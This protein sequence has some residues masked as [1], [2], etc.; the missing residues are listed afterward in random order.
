[1]TDYYTFVEDLAEKNESS[2]FNEKEAY[3]HYTQLSFKRMK[4][5]A[6]VGKLLPEMEEKIKSINEPQKWIVLTESWCG[7]AAHSYMFWQKMAD[8]NPNITL[9]WKLREEHPDLM[10]QYLTNGG[11][12]IPKLIAFNQEGEELFNWGPRP[13]H[14]QKRYWELREADKEYKEI[15]LEI[16]GLYN[17]DKGESLQRE[18][19][20]LMD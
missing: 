17:T 16:Q 19:L 20:D 6:K 14:I 5:W 13:K 4:R 2:S 1:M 8:L 12:S 3:K 10:E 18:M 7:D 11:K 9:E 15:M